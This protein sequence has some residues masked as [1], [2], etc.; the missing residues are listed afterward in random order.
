MIMQKNDEFTFLSF[1]SFV[2][3]VDGSCLICY[4]STGHLQVYSLPS[5]RQLVDVDFVPLADLRF[6][7]TSSVNLLRSE[8]PICFVLYHGQFFN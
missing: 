8:L 6:V 2:L 4:V 1:S 5:L 3:F 7:D